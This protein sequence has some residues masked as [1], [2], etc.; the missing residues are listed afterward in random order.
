MS[1]EINIHP[2]GY[3]EK[4]EELIAAVQSRQESGQSPY[5]HAILLTP[6]PDSEN[7]QHQGVRVFADGRITIGAHCEW[8]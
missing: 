8:I 2:Y 5:G 1:R 7:W 3:F 4:F 6:I